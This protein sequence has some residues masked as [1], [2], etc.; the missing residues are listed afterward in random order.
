M[1]ALGAEFAA[2]QFAALHQPG[3]PFLLPN[4]WD[5]A[6]ALMLAGAGFPAVGTTSMGVTAAAGL[7]DGAGTGRDETLALASAIVPRL[8]VPVTVDAEGGYS[9]DPAA[10]ADLAAGLAALGAAGINL[11]DAA[12]GGGLRPLPVQ[13]AIISAVAAAAPGLFVN[14]R[15]DVYWLRAG[16]PEDRLG[17]ALR[18]L[19]AY[20][21][22]GASG[23][24]V[25]ALTDIAAIGRVTAEVSLPLNLLWQPGQDMAEL[26]RAGVARISTGSGPYRR[27]LAAGLATAVAA[28]DGGQPPAP[29]ISYGDLIDLLDSYSTP[30]SRA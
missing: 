7:V 21:D 5:V 28:R 10:V 15:T 25:P 14:A 12:P 1:S 29:D 22:A 3:R 26:A 6:S 9:D 4:A 30:R 2:Q 20:A 24:F 17:E 18:R 23:I 11:E 19:H 16:A 8:P 13:A 27:A